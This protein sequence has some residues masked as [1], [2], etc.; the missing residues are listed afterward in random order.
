[1]KELRKRRY[2]P[3]WLRSEISDHDYLSVG[4]LG[5]RVEE[6][7]AAARDNVEKGSIIHGRVVL[8]TL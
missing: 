2:I 3:C 7:L 6:W 4:L 1:M 8:R 5:A